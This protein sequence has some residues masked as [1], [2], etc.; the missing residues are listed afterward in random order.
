MIW[1]FIAAFTC[2]TFVAACGDDEGDD[3]GG[4]RGGSGGSA[5]SAGTGGASD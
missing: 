1:V 2:L 4:G 5:G 3:D